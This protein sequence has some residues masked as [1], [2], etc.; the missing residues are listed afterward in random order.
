MDGCEQPQ[1]GLL[2]G[3]RKN[4]R[5]LLIIDVMGLLFLLSC[6]KTNLSHDKTKVSVFC[7]SITDVHTVLYC[8]DLF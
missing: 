6:R 4:L 7:V 2:K 5:F 3:G 8:I 1:E